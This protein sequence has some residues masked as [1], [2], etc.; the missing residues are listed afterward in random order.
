MAGTYAATKRW[1][2]NFKARDPEG[3]KQWRKAAKRR[4]YLKHKDKDY[5]RSRA[6]KTAHR[7]IV[8]EGERR[9]SRKRSKTLLAS[10]TLKMKYGITLEQKLALLA[11]QG[12]CCVI[13]GTKTPSKFRNSKEGWCVDHCHTYEQ[14]TGGI[15]IRGIL[16]TSCNNVLGFAHDNEQ[17]LLNAA[18]YVRKHRDTA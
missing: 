2:D 9:Y 1:Q 12:N 14:R 10:S 6:W 18:A 17:T 3:Y 11:S 15:K 8:R 16:C 13:C 5:A 4:H 7:E